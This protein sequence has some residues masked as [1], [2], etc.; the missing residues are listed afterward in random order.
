MHGAHGSLAHAWG[1]DRHGAHRQRRRRLHHRAHKAGLVVELLALRRGQLAQRFDGDGELPAGAPLVPQ[2]A[3]ILRPGQPATEGPPD[4]EAAG[5]PGAAGSC[6]TAWPGQAQRPQRLNVS[7]G[8]DRGG[9]SP[10]PR[11]TNAFSRSL[12]ASIAPIVA[13]TT[14]TGDSSRC[15]IRYASCVAVISA[16]SPDKGTVTSVACSRCPLVYDSSTARAMS[17]GTTSRAAAVIADVLD[18]SGYFPDKD[19]A[20]VGQGTASPRRAGFAG[21]RWRLAVGQLPRNAQAR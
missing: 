1:P 10:A 4:R 7:L 20:D 19:G 3:M 12:S 21:R 15:L 6:G 5:Q 17:G 13:S 18:F 2:P 8:V 11:C 9:C 14:S 16:S